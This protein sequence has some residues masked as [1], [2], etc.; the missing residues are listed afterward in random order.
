MLH[1]IPVS[2]APLN[3]LVASDERQAY[4]TSLSS[5]HQYFNCIALTAKLEQHFIA[6]LC[7]PIDNCGIKWTE[8]MLAL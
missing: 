2:A 7:T 3:S 8:S 5:C 6:V 1:S 4:N